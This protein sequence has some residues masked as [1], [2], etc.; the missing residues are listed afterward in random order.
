MR[1]SDVSSD[2]CPSDLTGG[3]GGERGQRADIRGA[4]ERTVRVQ[5]A[6]AGP[7]HR[8]RLDA[9]NHI[10]SCVASTQ[11]ELHRAG[12]FCR[13]LYLGPDL[14]PQIACVCFG[15]KKIP[16]P[17]GD[18]IFIRSEERRVGKEGVSPCRSR[19][20]PY[21]EKKKKNI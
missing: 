17:Q 16:S 3:A 7:G 10:G 15:A 18:G 8:A 4:R 12:A 2:V 9:G 5:S 1:I 20:S 13:C 14:T 19:W 6:T 11:G 21:H